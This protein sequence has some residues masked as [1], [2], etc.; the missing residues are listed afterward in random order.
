MEDNEEFTLTI[1]AESIPDGIIIGGPSTVI[2]R[3]DDS[4]Y[5]NYITIHIC[6]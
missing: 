4:E 5:A 6:S 3:N 2:I 1:N